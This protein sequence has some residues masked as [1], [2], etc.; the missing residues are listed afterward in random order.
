MDYF[1]GLL[2]TGE[3]SERALQLSTELITMNGSNFNV[4]FCLDLFVLFY[5]FYQ[6]D[7]GEN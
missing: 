5:I 3:K 7:G 2:Q 1:R 4:W 6:G